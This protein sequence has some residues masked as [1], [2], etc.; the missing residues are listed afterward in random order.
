METTNRCI[1]CY[2]TRPFVRGGTERLAASLASELE[3]QGYQVDQLTIPSFLGSKTQVLRE[4]LQWESLDLSKAYPDAWILTTKF[5]SYLLHHPR[6]IVWLF[7]QY[8]EVYDLYGN[9]LSAFNNE[10]L[11][12]DIREALMQLDRLALTEARGLF[13]ISTNVAKRLKRYLELDARVAYPP[14]P[15][16]G[17]LESRFHGDYVLAVSRLDPN[18]RIDLLLEA[19]ACSKDLRARIAGEGPLRGELESMAE[20]LGVSDRAHFLGPV[21][22]Q[23]LVDL[24]AEARAVYMGPIDEDY[25]L[26]TLEAMEAERPVV[27]TSDSG[28]PLEFVEHEVNGIVVEPRPEEL[29]QAL[30]RLVAN[31]ALCRKLGAEGRETVRPVVWE[32]AIS[33]LFA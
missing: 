6:K 8:R 13:S 32:S 7:H 1:V 18:K 2:P 15:L 23:E 33:E 17:H 19:L 29:A 3:R 24:Y 22:D 10:V 28:G 30:E 26:V 31:D 11:D 4:A 12:H 27:A 25:G 21:S 14:S 16:S 5:P 9:R 20:Q